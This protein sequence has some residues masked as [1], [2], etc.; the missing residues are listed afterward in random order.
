MK[1]KTRQAILW[2]LT[3]AFAAAAIATIIAYV[4]TGSSQTTAF[5]WTANVAIVTGI[6]DA[7][8]WQR[9]RQENGDASDPATRGPAAADAHQGPPMSRRMHRP[10]RASSGAPDEAAA[11]ATP[12]NT[13]AETDQVAETHEARV[14]SFEEELRHV[15]A[16]RD[17]LASLEDELADARRAAEASEARVESLQG[18]LDSVRSE[19]D[20]LAPLVQRLERVEQE[21]DELAAHARILESQITEWQT[22]RDRLVA[23]AETRDQARQE[24]AEA[25]RRA[26]GAEKQLEA[27]RGENDALARRLAAAHAEI[28]RLTDEL[29]MRKRPM[30]LAD[31][32][33][34]PPAE[35]VMTIEDLRTA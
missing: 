3:G 10:E 7:V 29:D 24:T 23:L 18:H 15:R 20:R 12:A 5:Q 26:E 21:R 19:R 9:H 16:E 17:R 31:L 35:D 30:R 6:A 25:D 11:A 4:V 8:A 33:G 1:N 2:G 28:A 34:G 13:H 14:E 32:F 27:A 22:D